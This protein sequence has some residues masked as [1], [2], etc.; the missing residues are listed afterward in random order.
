MNQ[1][2]K[3]MNVTFECISKQYKGKYALQNFSSSLDNGVYGLL[4]ANGAG[5]TTLINIFVGILKNDGGCIFVD[6]KDTREIGLN[7]LSHIGYLPQYP[8]FYRSFEVYDF[9][10]YIGSLKDIQAINSSIVLLLNYIKVPLVLL[11]KIK[12]QRTNSDYISVLLVGLIVYLAN[13]RLTAA[14]SGTSIP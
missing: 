7:F 8:R 12:N 4:G 14:T 6:G 2:D 11:L 3:P 5:K 10:L 9:L 13:P 1:E